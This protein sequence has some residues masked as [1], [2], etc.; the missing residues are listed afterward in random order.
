MRKTLPFFLLLLA[1][2]AFLTPLYPVYAQTAGDLAA[3]AA[4]TASVKRI[5]RP[6]AASAAAKLDAARD[7]LENKM[8]TAQGK[9]EDARDKLAT[10][11]AALKTKLAR[12]RDKAKAARVE[13]VNSNLAA[14]NTRRT[15]Q[16]S[17]SLNHIQTVLA[18][19]KTWVAEQEAAGKDV[20]DLKTAITNTEAVWAE[21]DAAIKDQSDNDY[22]IEVNTEATVKADAREA[23]D[24]LRTDLKAVHDK[25][26][27][28]RQTLV[29]ALSSWK[30][31]N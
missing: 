24:T 21:A 15:S 23:R 7:K 3:P 10:R 27:S 11:A 26:V 1:V 17:Q 20:A 8:T 5:A 6:N 18:K 28:V 19:L 2:T 31:G 30:G 29:S 25:L 13:N 14:I 4:P 12:F 22:T 16:M 9:L